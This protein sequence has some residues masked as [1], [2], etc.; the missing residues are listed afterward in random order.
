MV[1]EKKVIIS[2][3]LPLW[4]KPKDDNSMACVRVTGS[5]TSGP[6]RRILIPKSNMMN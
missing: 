3:T 4:K 6:K 5:A 2:R 1:L